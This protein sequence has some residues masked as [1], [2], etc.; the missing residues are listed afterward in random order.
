M[1]S[2]FCH[3]IAQ[4]QYTSG[5]TGASTAAKLMGAAGGLIALTKMPA[6]NVMLLGSQK[7]TLTGFSSTAINP[8]T[9]TKKQFL[10]SH[11]SQMCLK[12]IWL[13]AIHCSWFGVFDLVYETKRAVSWQASYL[14]YQRA[15][16]RHCSFM[17][18][19]FYSIVSGTY[20]LSYYQFMDMIH[21]PSF[22]LT[23]S[24]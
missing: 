9:G 8:H 6:C 2:W 16:I 22:S 20:R 23:S 10:K 11:T 18:S 14:Y 5:F 17:R 4:C 3:V 19:T 12:Q 24:F 13:G 1:I 15:T 21:L 7:R